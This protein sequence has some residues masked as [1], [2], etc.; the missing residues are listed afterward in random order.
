MSPRRPA[1]EPIPLPTNAQMQAH[2][3]KT[4]NKE[5]K[6]KQWEERFD[7]LNTLRQSLDLPPYSDLTS[8]PQHQLTPSYIDKLQESIYLRQ[9]RQQGRHP[10]LNASVDP[11]F[12]PPSTPTPSI[13]GHGHKLKSSSKTHIEMH[14]RITDAGMEALR[15]LTLPFARL[16]TQE[17]SDQK[18]ANLLSTDEHTYS[19]YVRISYLRQQR[20]QTIGRRKKK[21]LLTGTTVREQEL[22]PHRKIGVGLELLSSAIL[23]QSDGPQDTR[24]EHIKSEDIERLTALIK[25]PSRKWVGP[26]WTPDSDDTPGADKRSPRCVVISQHCYDNLLRIAY[27]LHVIN[28]RG[29]LDDDARVRQTIEA[30]ALG[31]IS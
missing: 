19:T 22:V 6:R 23:S 9:R 11:N 10:S 30:I 29:Y 18:I 15:N 25:D 13:V 2:I 26:Q 3:Q 16:A 4:T 31:W 5:A 8:V 21:S 14:F 28:S 7:T 27:L 24:P 17:D 20:Q 12:P 1:N